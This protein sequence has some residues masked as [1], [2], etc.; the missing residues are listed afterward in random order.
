M[1]C[2]TPTG[3]PP[4]CRTEVHWQDEKRTTPEYGRALIEAFEINRETG[5]V[6]AHKEVF[7]RL[8]YLEGECKGWNAWR[9]K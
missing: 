1:G 6:E 3:T 2:R 9:K 5:R 7:D 4:R 8:Q